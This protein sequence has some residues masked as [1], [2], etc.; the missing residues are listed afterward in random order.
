LAAAVVEAEQKHR[1]MCKSDLEVKK[2]EFGAPNVQKCAA[3][4][5]RKS[6]C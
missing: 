3:R 6:D 2:L 4:S 1:K 5:E